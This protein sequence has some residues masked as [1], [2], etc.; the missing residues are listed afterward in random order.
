MDLSILPEELRLAIFQE[1]ISSLLLEKNIRLTWRNNYEKL[2]DYKYICLHMDSLNNLGYFK[3]DSS[4]IVKKFPNININL[5]QDT[6]HLRKLENSIL[7]PN[8]TI[9]ALVAGLISLITFIC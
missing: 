4:L 3:F 1:V 2:Q 5:L 9:E 7:T 6:A 8:Q